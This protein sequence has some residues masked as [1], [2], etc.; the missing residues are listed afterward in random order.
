MF[1]SLVLSPHF[2]IQTPV[3][4]LGNHQLTGQVEKL[5]DPYCLMEKKYNENVTPKQI[6]AYQIIG[7]V[8]E[9]L[10]FKNYPKAI[11]R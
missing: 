9:K 7:I 3:M 6:E 10:L 5:D 2:R 4:I 11:M 1:V 8:T